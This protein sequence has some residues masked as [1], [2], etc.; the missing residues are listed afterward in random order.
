MH[1]ISPQRRALHAIIQ[2]FLTLMSGC[3]LSTNYQLPRVGNECSHYYAVPHLVNPPLPQ[4]VA[5]RCW[6]CQL[7]I[8]YVYQ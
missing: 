8:Y 2:T 6:L 3:T 4:V 7:A 1:E 5:S